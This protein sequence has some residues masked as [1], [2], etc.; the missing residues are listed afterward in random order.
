LTGTR[1]A[2][3]QRLRSISV[4]LRHHWT[5]LAPG[6]AVAKLGATWGHKLRIAAVAIIF[7]QW[8]GR[9]PG[10][11]ARL[12]L[13]WEGHDIE[14]VINDFSELILIN[15]IFWGR[16]YELP[17]A[18]PPLTVLDLGANIGLA[19]VFFRFLYPDADVIAVEP[20]PATFRRLVRNVAPYG[21]RCFNVAVGGVDGRQKLYRTTQSWE[22]AL[23]PDVTG[24][25]D[26]VE[27]DVRSLDTLMREIDVQK[28][29]LIKMD[30]EGAEYDALAGYH[31]L[32]S[33][34]H[35]TGEFHANLTGRSTD[36]FASLLSGFDVGIRPLDAST[37]IF[38]A[39]RRARRRRRS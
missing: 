22:A 13:R 37:A 26:A 4:G 18:S 10:R 30:V 2:V 29:D 3:S 14:L 36:E 31:G 28:I 38:T 20:D 7:R 6:L 19:S 11:L 34:E 17:L 8:A 16:Q 39:H 9:R 12:R 25:D 1:R 33:V 35:L 21:V 27:V 32:D 23:V 5:L 24:T 15:E